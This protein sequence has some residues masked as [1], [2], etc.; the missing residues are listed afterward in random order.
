MSLRGPGAL[1]WVPEPH[2]IFSVIA[3]GFRSQLLE[4]QRWIF[5][6]QVGEE[7]IGIGVTGRCDGVSGHAPCAGVDEVIQIVQLF[8][9]HVLLIIHGPYLNSFGDDR[10]ESYA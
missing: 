8:M 10:R 1:K 9:W 7:V 6:G 5:Q 4:G 3:G 2:G